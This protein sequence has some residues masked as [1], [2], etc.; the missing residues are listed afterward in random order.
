[1]HSH[2]YAAPR[3]PTLRSG[4]LR[5]TL[6]ESCR[7][8]LRLSSPPA[9]HGDHMDARETRS[10]VAFK[11]QVGHIRH[12]GLGDKSPKVEAQC[13]KLEASIPRLERLAG[14]V[15]LAQKTALRG[16]NVKLWRNRLRNRSLRGLAYAAKR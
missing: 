11:K 2:I 4:V 3:P 10:L 15:H 13:S 9:K 6:G 1:M 5:R 7:A 16:R 14:D 8:A 12:Y